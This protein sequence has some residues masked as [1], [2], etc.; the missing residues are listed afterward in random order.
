MF[1]DE[2]GI[3]YPILLGENDAAELGKLAGNRLSDGRAV[4]DWGLSCT[5]KSKSG[6]GAQP[7]AVFS[8]HERKA[9]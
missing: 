2:M 5:G 1:S 8:N 6:R 9:Q 4:V 7:G 3:N